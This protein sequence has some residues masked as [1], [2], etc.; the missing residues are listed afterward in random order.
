MTGPLNLK[1]HPKAA[2]VVDVASDARFAEGV[3]LF[4]RGEFWHAHE[5]WEP[6]WMG[7]EGDEKLWLQGL[8]MA[9]AMLHQYERGIVRGVTNHWANVERRIGQ[10]PPRR[11]GVDGAGLLSQLAPFAADAAAG[12]PLAR[13]TRVVRLRGSA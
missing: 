11:W 10:G 6:V 4:N 1:R 2:P 12:R 8:I 13:D 7:L 5:A 9:A 3:D